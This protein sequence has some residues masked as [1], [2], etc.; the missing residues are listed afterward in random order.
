MTHLRSNHPPLVASGAVSG[1]GPPAP[2]G[3][4]W[5]PTWLQTIAGLVVA[6]VALSGLA[7][8]GYRGN[9]TVDVQRSV[10]TIHS[11]QLD[12]AFYHCLDVQTHS[13]VSP[14]QP[15]II[16][17]SNFA[18]FITLLK[19]VGSWVRIADPPSTLVAFLSLRDN[20]DGPGACLGTVVV[21]RYSKGPFRATVRIGSGS[22][23]PGHGPPPA[24]PL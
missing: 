24:P 4:N 15:V 9:R 23:V 1:D 21:A 12:D 7:V 13:L 18:N 19:A 3:R 5:L 14:G 22:S 6:A 11:A 16:D 8:Q 20:V 10:S 2:H 17:E